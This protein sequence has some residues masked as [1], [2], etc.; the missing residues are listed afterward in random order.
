MFTS[1]TQ[2]RGL[3]GCTKENPIT[4]PIPSTFSRA[5]YPASASVSTASSAS[6][7]MKEDWGWFIGGDD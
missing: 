5:S 4:V 1:V 2:Q 6:S 7:S 3:R